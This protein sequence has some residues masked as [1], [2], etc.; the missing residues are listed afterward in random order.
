MM[1]KE[2][3]ISGGKVTKNEK[4]T[5]NIKN[6]GTYFNLFLRHLLFFLSALFAKVC[7]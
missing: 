2:E 6:K 1:I 4:I 5:D 3:I 7:V